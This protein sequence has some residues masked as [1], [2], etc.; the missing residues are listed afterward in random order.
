MSITIINSKVSYGPDLVTDGLVLYLDA[1]N[2]NS[3]PG[4]GT[5]WYDLSGYN[6]NATI[7]NSPS[8]NGK[9]FTLDTT[10][11][12]ENSNPIPSQGTT[13]QEWTVCTFVNITDTTYQDLVSDGDLN[14]GLLLRAWATNAMILYLN[15]TPNDYYKYSTYDANEWL[16]NQGWCYVE[17]KFRNSDATRELRVNLT[18]HTGSGPNQTQTPLGNASTWRWLNGVDGDVSMIMMYDRLIT[19]IESQKNFNAL[20]SRFG[21]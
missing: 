21:H 16:F 18:D 3:Y 13:D 7:Y 2:S 19:N 4:S 17:F 8:H 9:Y 11:Y 12:I 15:A 1:A 10:Q 20:K 5:I 14:R 6:K